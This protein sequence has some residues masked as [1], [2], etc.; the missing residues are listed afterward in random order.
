MA[1]VYTTLLNVVIMVALFWMFLFIKNRFLNFS[2]GVVII[3]FGFHMGFPSIIMLLLSLFV[4][5]VVFR[6]LR[7]G[8]VTVA[9]IALLILPMALAG[10]Q[11]GHNPNPSNNSISFVQKVGEVGRI[12]DQPKL[13]V[14]GTDYLT[15]DNGKLQAYVTQAELPINNATCFVSVLYPN[16]SIFLDHVLMSPVNNTNFAGL[17]TFDFTVPNATGVYPVNANCFY[18]V[19]QNKDLVVATKGNF[20]IESGNIGLLEFRDNTGIQYKGDN[21]CNNAFC[22]ATFNITLPAGYNTPFLNDFRLRTKMSTTTAEDFNVTV[23]NN[24]TGLFEEWFIFNKNTANNDV[25]QQFVLNDSYVNTELT[26]LVRIGSDDFDNGLLD[27]DLLVTNREYNGTSVVD[28]RGNSELVISKKLDNATTVILGDQEF[29]TPEV[30]VNILLLIGAFV[31][32]AVN[33]FAGGALLI[34]WVVLYSNNIY[35]ST[36]FVL[37]SLIVMISGRKKE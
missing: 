5:I 10:H 37:F 14:L 35:I 16:E 15:F 32:M 31:A 34:M 30:A 6:H 21:S 25:E 11:A 1:I 17:H 36:L 29:V 18:N 20:T 4:F 26:I 7:A 22:A 24:D 33:A 8:A 19:T 28:L 27:V 9:L 12:T 13:Q 23:F 3:L 2:T